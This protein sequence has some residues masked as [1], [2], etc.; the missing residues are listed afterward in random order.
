MDSCTSGVPCLAC[1]DQA[2]T[3]SLTSSEGS[4]VARGQFL[5][6][7]L[8]NQAPFSLIPG[9]SSENRS[10]QVTATQQLLC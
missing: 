6:N 2:K 5:G 10:C 3:G 8:Q 1:G 7:T 9:A 4:Q